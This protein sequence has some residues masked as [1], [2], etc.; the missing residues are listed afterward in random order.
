MN[1]IV[2]LGAGGHARVVIE[3]I[4]ADPTAAICGVLSNDRSTWG[5][6]LA[7]VAIIGGD[8]QLRQL[9]DSNHCDSFVIAIGGIKTFALRSRLF[10]EVRELGLLPYSVRHSSC[11]CS[12]SA[13]IADGSQLLARSV[14]NADAEICENVIINTAAIVEHDCIVGAHSHVAPQACLAGGVRVGRESHIGLGAVVKENL[15]IGDRVVIG[16]GGV[17]VADVPSNAIVVGVP[18]RPIRRAN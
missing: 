6:S 7:G 9:C 8:D 3:A 16:A 18:A 11:I 10:T 12:P 13:K 14:V 5:T 4:A 1:R 15:S 2:I 17:V